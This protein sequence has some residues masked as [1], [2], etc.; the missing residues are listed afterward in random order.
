[1]IFGEAKY[2]KDYINSLRFYMKDNNNVMDF[3]TGLSNLP[4]QYDLGKF[5]SRI[6][7]ISVRCRWDRSCVFL[8]RINCVLPL[9]SLV[10]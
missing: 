5:V 1:M 9:Q 6:E 8:C 4:K 7:K 2:K 10:R 3:Y